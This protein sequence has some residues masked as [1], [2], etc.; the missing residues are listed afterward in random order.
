MKNFDL[1]IKKVNKTKMLLLIF[2]N[3]ADKSIKYSN[4]QNF[5]FEQFKL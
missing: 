1:K 4:S 5:K 2:N 3:R